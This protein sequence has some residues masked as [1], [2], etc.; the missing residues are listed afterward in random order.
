[1]VTGL[2]VE[3]QSLPW[4]IGTVSCISSSAMDLACDFKGGGYS[5]GCSGH[6]AALSS[7]V[8]FMNTPQN[9]TVF[10]VKIILK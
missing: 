5:Y 3:Q 1:M 10:T 8:S 2:S 9:F 4:T 6:V 7:Q